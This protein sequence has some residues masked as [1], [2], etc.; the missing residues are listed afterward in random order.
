MNSTINTSLLIHSRFPQFLKKPK[1]FIKI[2]I[3]SV[4][5]G[6]LYFPVFTSMGNDWINLPDFSHGFFIPF[7]S[8][9]FVW[10]RADKLGNTAL[11]PNNSG[12]FIILLGL[13]LFFV[14]N[15][16]LESFTMQFSF[17]IVLSGIVLF[18]LGWVHFK[19]LLFPIAFLIFM[20]P[21][22]S[23]LMGKITFPMQLFASKVATGS[24]SMLGIPILR[25]G[26]IIILADTTLAVAEACSGIRSLISL[27][28]IGTV[29]AYFTKKSF[30]QRAVLILSCLPVAIF[31]NALRVTATGVLSNAYGPSVAQGFFHGF[32]GYLLFLVALV[33]L[34]GEG[35]LLSRF[36]RE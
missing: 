12:F 18:L 6:I 21:I 3:C 36:Q 9:Y 28:A 2:G 29:F 23:I 16:G 20:I 17:L 19:I 11:S 15:L 10:E 24:L 14:G 35:S 13:M 26:N 4:C 25:E 7:I 27:L 1:T 31:V 34:V 5:L 22:P 32:S 8:L 33:L 30:W